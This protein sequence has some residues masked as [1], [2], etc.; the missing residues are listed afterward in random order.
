[1]AGGSAKALGDGRSQIIA[2][3]VGDGVIA[4]QTLEYLGK[5]LIILVI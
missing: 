3:A 5:Y 2:L 4:L 1:M